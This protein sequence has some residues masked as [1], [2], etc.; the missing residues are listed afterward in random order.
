MLEVKIPGLYK[1]P[2][3]QDYEVIIDANYDGKIEAD[4][5]SGPEINGMLGTISA[6]RINVPVSVVVWSKGP[7]K[8]DS[9]TAGEKANQDNVYSFETNWRSGDGHMLR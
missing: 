7:D 8:A 9:T 6:T 4:P 2:W 3:E 5:A 1:D